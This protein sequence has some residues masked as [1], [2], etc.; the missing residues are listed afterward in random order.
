MIILFTN[1]L[2][3]K[4]YMQYENNHISIKISD[5]VFRS[6]ESIGNALSIPIEYISSMII[7][8]VFDYTSKSNMKNNG[9]CL[10]R[11][12]LH[13]PCVVKLS[14]INKNI[15]YKSASIIDISIFGVGIVI[16]G[17]KKNMEHLYS[18]IKEFELVLQFGDDLA[19]TNY[20]CRICHV[21]DDSLLRL[22]G[23][24]IAPEPSAFRR[25]LRLFMLA[26]APVAA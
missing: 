9:R 2:I 3:W 17:A 8:S 15:T 1:L 18:N 22:G 4:N 24:L 5:A 10:L 6:F 13:V 12:K 20:A 23:V 25:F 7:D 11:K 14:D 16:H 26:E 21:K 19:A